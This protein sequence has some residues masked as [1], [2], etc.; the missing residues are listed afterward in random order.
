M[1]RTPFFSFVLSFLA[2]ILLLS[3]CDFEGTARSEIRNQLQEAR[4]KWQAQGTEN[5]RFVYSQQRGD[6]IIDT[7]E[8]FVRGGRM[9]S[10]RTVPD[11]GEDEPL[12]G[13]IASF[14]DLIEAR[15]GESDSQF[16][17]NFDDTRGFPVNYNAGFQDDRRSQD[18]ITLEVTA[19]GESQTGVPSEG[20]RQ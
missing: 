18:I 8:V 13:T 4:E 10:I 3:G 14:F 15:V 20:G 12:V 2:G 19:Q 5:Y 11:V 9:D 6:V 16:G 7:V 1:K 17:A